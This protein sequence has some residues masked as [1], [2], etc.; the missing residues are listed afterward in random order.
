[1]MPDE[2]IHAIET[3]LQA[4]FH[5][6]VLEVQDDSAAHAGHAGSAGGAGH[7][8]VVIGAETFQSLSRI[9]VH[10]AV[11]GVLADLIPEEIH[12]LRIQVVSGSS[13]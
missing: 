12:A 6:A 4:A 7:Y 5:P 3:R 9:A 2:R 11:Y 10:R 13:P 8:T 1:M